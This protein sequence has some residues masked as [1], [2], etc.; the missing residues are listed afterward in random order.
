MKSFRLLLLGLCALALVLIALAICYGCTN[1]HPAP[2]PTRWTVQASGD[3]ATVLSAYRDL[4][5][6]RVQIGACWYVLVVSTGGY[7][8]S[9]AITHAAD[10]PNPFHGPH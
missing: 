4:E 3:T 8:S 5:I 1:G 6:H 7:S 9:V 10:C 2:E